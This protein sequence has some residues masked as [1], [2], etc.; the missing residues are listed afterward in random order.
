M[1]PRFPIDLSLIVFLLKNHVAR[2]YGDLLKRVWVADCLGPITLLT[3]SCW[4][5]R[6]LKFNFAFYVLL[7]I[8]VYEM[9]SF[10][11]I[12]ESPEYVH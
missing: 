9:C 8:V 11:W 2:T 12:E 10:M 3:P 4:L 6:Q 5:C 7:F 1:E